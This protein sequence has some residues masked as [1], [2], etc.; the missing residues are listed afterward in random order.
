MLRARRITGLTNL[1]N[2]EQT[3]HAKKLEIYWK[4]VITE[5]NKKD[6]V[7]QKL[8]EEKEN[9]NSQSKKC[10]TT[11]TLFCIVQ[12]N[13]H[14]AFA[15]NI[16]KNKTISELKSLIQKEKHND[17]AGID[18]DQLKLWQVEIPDDCYDELTNSQL[19]GNNELLATK[20]ISKYFTKNPAD[21]HIHIIVT[22]PETTKTRQELELINNNFLETMS[23]L[24]LRK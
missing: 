16:N 4:E 1:V 23:F 10:Q 11:I 15:I 9:F 5:L 13:A 2:N 19:F 6:S 3:R 7:K 12:G 14:N 21:E 18:P 24:Q 17:F 20:K 22:L 8:E